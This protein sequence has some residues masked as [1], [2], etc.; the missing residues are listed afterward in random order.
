MLIPRRIIALDDPLVGRQLFQRH[1]TARVQFLCADR[2]FRAHTHCAAI[3]ETRAG[4]PVDCG[5]IHCVEEALG[6]IRRLG[7]DAVGVLGAMARDMRDRLVDA[8]DYFQVERQVIPLGVEVFV[9]RRYN[10]RSSPPTMA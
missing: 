1:W 10:T 2:D 7:Q 9:N 5:R 3:G 4:I 6:M 8:A